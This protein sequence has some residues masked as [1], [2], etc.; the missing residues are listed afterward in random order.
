MTDLPPTR[1]ELGGQGRYAAHFA[2]LIAEGKDIDG[3]AR[4]ADALVSPGARI[5]D[6]GSGIGRVGA[7]LLAR[8]HQ[9]IA[10]EKDPELVAESRRRYPTLPV[11]ETDLLALNAEVVEPGFDLIV[12][13]GNVIV[14]LAPGTERRLLT[15][16]RDLLAPTGRILVGFHPLAGHGSARDYPVAEFVADVTASGLVVQHRFGT[17]ELGPASDAYC[18]AVLAQPPG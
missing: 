4:L 9:V 3:E 14:L 5:L 16:L 1:W 15:G 6:G 8:G 10:A 2:E 13:V 12:L 18:V 11:L 7:T 17:Y